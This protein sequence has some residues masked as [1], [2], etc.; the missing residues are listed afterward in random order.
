MDPLESIKVHA[1]TSFA[2]ALKAQEKGH[3]IYWAM[4]EHLL[5]RDAI[6][7]VQ[8]RKIK[9][10]R[11]QPCW[12]FLAETKEEPA[13]DFD[14]ILIRK[15]PPFDEDYF[16][17]THFL[18]LCKKAKVVNRPSALREAPEKLY[19]LN[20]PQIC[21]PTIITRDGEEIR[22]FMNEQGGKIILKP[23]NRCGGAG[24]IMLTPEDTNFNSL[25]ELSTNDGKEHII[26]QR[27]LPEIKKGDKRV[28]VILGQPYDGLLRK[29]MDGET[30]SNLHAGGTGSLEPLSER[31]VWLIDQIKDKLLE[32]GLYFVGVDVIGDYIT[33]INVTSPTG[34]Q[35]V[36]DLG[37][38]DIADDFWEKLDQFKG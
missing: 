21:P 31:E 3:D 9:F 25:V 30:R 5:I 16:M 26:A 14:V 7:S 33:E 1:D 35:A 15:D 8:A 2:L 6:P 34:I 10:V 37:G 11:A 13:D 23:L 29:P 22:T 17:T 4:S 38:P 18:S 27:Y 24:I 32:D 36:K 28:N 19:P 20:F 12:E